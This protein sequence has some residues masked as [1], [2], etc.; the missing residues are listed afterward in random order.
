MGKNPNPVK[1][2]RTRT[3]VLSRTEQNSN[4][5]V[6]CKNPN[7]TEPYP[8]KNRTEPEPKCHGSYSVLLLKNYRYIHTFH[9]KR[10]ILLY[11]GLTK[12]KYQP[13]DN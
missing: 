10:D 5:K 4:P 12:F 1:M 6:K 13:N 11:S 2:N 8:V 9:S 3:R 7:R